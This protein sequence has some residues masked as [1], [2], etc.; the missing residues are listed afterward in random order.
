ML[1]CNGKQQNQTMMIRSNYDNR[2]G[3]VDGGA[4]AGAD[5]GKMIICKHDCK[6]KKIGKT[7][8]RATTLDGS[9][10]FEAKSVSK[11][12]QNGSQNGADIRQ[13]AIHKL[14]DK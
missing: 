3:G 7:K 12:S 13:N 8:R 4:A 10:D 2:L 9:R 11:A 5:N 1:W 14:I 6:L